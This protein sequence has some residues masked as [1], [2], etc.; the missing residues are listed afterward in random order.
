R[1]AA[2]SPIRPFSIRSTRTRGS[3]RSGSAS[4][5]ICSP[6]VVT[7]ADWILR[8]ILWF[9]TASTIH[10]ILHEGAHALMAFALNVPNTLY[11]Y[12][13]DWP[14]AAATLAQEAAIR[15]WGP[16]FSLIAGLCFWLA[17]SKR[18]PQSAARLP[19]L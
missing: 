5:C 14:P 2:R 4:C 3:S 13:V 10:V 12:W 17:Y 9:T 16:T 15:A 19:L 6:G 1:R 11:Q 7:R 8:P 18:T